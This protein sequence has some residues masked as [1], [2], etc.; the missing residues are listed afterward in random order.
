M[1]GYTDVVQTIFVILIIVGLFP[2][3]PN[4]LTQSKA[5]HILGQKFTAS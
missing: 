4:I 1:Q 2:D 5:S 3:R